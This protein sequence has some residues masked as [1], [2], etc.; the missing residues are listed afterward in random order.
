MNFNR[1]TVVLQL[2]NAH[3]HN[4][5]WAH[6]TYVFCFFNRLLQT[7]NLNFSVFTRKKTTKTVNFDFVVAAASLLCGQHHHQRCWRTQTTVFVFII[8]RREGCSCCSDVDS[9]FYTNVTLCARLGKH[10]ILLIVYLNCCWLW[11]RCGP[12]L[13]TAVWFVSKSS[14]FL[15]VLSRA[16]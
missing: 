10:T 13:F 12:R 2:H 3:I 9:E 14:V 11:L 4:C 6:C 5:L 7:L 15:L 16:S 1:I 8:T